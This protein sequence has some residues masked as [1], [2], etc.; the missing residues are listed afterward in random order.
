LR[1]DLARVP[2]VTRLLEVPNV[3]DRSVSADGSETL[4]VF[5]CE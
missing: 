3:S 2:A 1:P 4:A 5:I